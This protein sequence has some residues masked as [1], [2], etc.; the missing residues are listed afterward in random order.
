VSH[1]TPEHDPRNFKPD[2]FHVCATV[3]FEIPG[4]SELELSE[5]PQASKRARHCDGFQIFVKKEKSYMLFVES[6]DT[7]LCIKNVIQAMEGLPS[8]QQ[9]LTFGGKP[10]ANS[11]TLADYNIIAGCQLQLT[12][13]LR[14]GMD[15]G[16]EGLDTMEM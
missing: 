1:P 10:L 5:T 14:G 3:G 16:D 15:G 2:G 9:R 7:V 12:M 11:Q 6:T 13:G 4:G 8:D